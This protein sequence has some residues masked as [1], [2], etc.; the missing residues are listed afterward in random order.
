[1]DCV[2]LKVVP[3]PPLRRGQMPRPPPRRQPPELLFAQADSEGV[4][5]EPSPIPA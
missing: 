1:M 2:S 3:L 4:D 5:D